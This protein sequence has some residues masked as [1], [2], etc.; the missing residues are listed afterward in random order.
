MK[1]YIILILVA[2]S[3]FSCEKDLEIDLTNAETHIV[4]NGLL[5]PDSLIKIRISESK[6]ILDNTGANYLIN[7][8]VRLFEDGSLIENMVYNTNENYFI[9]SVHPAIGRSYSIEVDYT[10]LES[11]YSEN[12]VSE[13]VNIISS[14]ATYKIT[15]EIDGE[16]IKTNYETRYN[17][18]IND[19]DNEENYYFISV[20]KLRHYQTEINGMT[21]YYTDEYSEIQSNDIVLGS[22]Y[23]DFNILGLSGKVFSDEDFNGSSGTINFW[24]STSYT[25]QTNAVNNEF[26]Y[27][28]A[29]I[30]KDLYEYVISYNKNKEN[31][32]IPFSQP[33]QIYSNIE[34][35]RGV[36]S[37]FTPTYEIVISKSSKLN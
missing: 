11:V 28:I 26:A 21:N 19:T 24:I 10:G 32:D 4:V 7:A 20:P 34:N 27:C 31:G 8:Q 15:E 18:N 13:Y 25:Q 37:G 17:I 3:I 6:N 30:S 5:N 33:T 35:G 36:F 16:N 29:S 23:N 12:I 2:I 22:I 9:S 14:D 1:K